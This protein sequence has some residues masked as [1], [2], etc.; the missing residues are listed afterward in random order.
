[1]I[2]LKENTTGHQ[3]AS[4]HSGRVLKQKRIIV[5]AKR[6]LC[7]EPCIQPQAVYLLRIGKAVS[8]GHRIALLH[9]LSQG[10]KSVEYLSQ[11]TGLS[12]ANTSQHLQQLRHTGMVISRKSGQHVFYCLTNDTKIL[13]LIKLIQSLAV[14][15][16]AE[17]KS[18]ISEYPGHSE[19]PGPINATELSSDAIFIDPAR[20]VPTEQPAT[21]NCEHRIR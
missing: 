4:V 6:K 13:T 16:L 9:H 3:R 14:E 12:I 17:I 11:L 10:E 19:T 21:L 2:T 8:N 1:M 15:Q 20:P 5:F 7:H 18:L